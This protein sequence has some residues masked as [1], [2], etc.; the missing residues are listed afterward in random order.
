MDYKP[1]ILLNIDSLMAN[2]L[3]VAI[4]TG[5]APALQ[6]LMENGKYY[7]EVV[8]SFPTMSVTVDSTLL[9]G[10]YADKHHIPGLNW[11]DTNKKEIINYGTGFF[12]TFRLG[13]RRSIHNMLYRLNHEHMSQDVTTIYE[14]LA[15]QGLTSGSIN[16][17][18]YRGNTP[19]TL[20]VPRLFTALTYFKDGKWTAETP[21]IF[22][23]GAFSKLKPTHFTMKIAAGNYKY[24]ARELR[25]LIRKN[26]LPAFTF[27]IFQDL[28]LRIHIKGAMDLAGITRIDKQIQKTLNLYTS[29]EEAIN[30]NC[31]LIMGDNG[32]APLRTKYKEALIDLRTIFKKYR[33]AKINRSIHRK[34]QLVFC[35]NQRM[36]YIYTLD[37]MLAITTIVSQLKQDNRIDIIAW[38]EENWIR[39]ESAQKEGTLYYRPGEDLSDV[40]KQTWE[41]K[42]EISL[43]DLNVGK[44]GILDYDNFPD[45][46]A[47]LYGSL[48]SQSGIFL[49]VNAKP[50]HEFKAQSTPTHPSAAHGSLHKQESLVPLI[51]TGTEE[52][53]KY[54]R[55]ID[56]KEFILRIAGK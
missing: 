15:H 4:Q 18:V 43:L 32:Q 49:V 35:V 52:E 56:L 17:F 31:W 44:D 11:F 23:L 47:R 10:T 2:P 40:Y 27:C 12:E 3:E 53:P 5:R 26:K 30:Q 34:D 33:I 45:A 42:G 21:P 8:S 6:F 9:T 50:G 39:V 51:I 14:E 46:L 13:T 37:S 41:V 48:H 28:D 22:S 24:T 20:K 29:W 54:S 25:H 55:H 16:S 38:K 36:A 7:P 1:V 19:R